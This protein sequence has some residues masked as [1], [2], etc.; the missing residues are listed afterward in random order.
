M[1]H[2]CVCVSLFGLHQ[3]Q[4][5]IRNRNSAWMFI[6]IFVE[7]FAFKLC[8]ASAYCNGKYAQ[9][10]YSFGSFGI[11]DVQRRQRWQSLCVPVHTFGTLNAWEKKWA[12][13]HIHTHTVRGSVRG[14]TRTERKV[15]D[16]AQWFTINWA[17]YK[18]DF[19]L[20]NLL[21]FAALPFII[22]QQRKYLKIV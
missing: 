1:F 20:S 15:D 22:L 4:F 19:E 14:E 8:I 16:C 18:R 6:F 12:R 13:E 3:T 17:I 21:T 5:H 9:L 11:D 10:W 2:L 7:D